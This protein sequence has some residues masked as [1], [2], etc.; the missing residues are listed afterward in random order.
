V[1]NEK[2]TIINGNF[3]NEIRRMELFKDKNLK[4]TFS[5]HD[6]F[7]CRQFWLKKGYD[8]VFEQ[9][10]FSNDNAVVKLGVGK[11][12]VSAIRYWL[13]AFTITDSQDLITPFGFELLGDNGLDPFLEDDGSLWLL[14]YNL[15]KSGHA[16]IY[17]IIFN[18]FRR[19]KIEF[20]RESFLAFIKR[21]AE[22]EKGINFNEKTIGEDFIVFRKMYLSADKSA[23]D[24]LAGLLSDLG[25][26]KKIEK[27]IDDKKVDFFVI[28]NTERPQIPVE[29]FLYSILDNENYTNSISLNSLVQDYNSPGSIFAMNSHGIIEK[30]KEAETKYR[31][32][33]YNDNA[34]VKEIQ[35]R[36]KP[37]PFTV[38]ED[39]Y[40]QE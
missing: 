2:L 21:K 26:I 5:G 14:H 8:F 38:L 11:N 6:S 34:G 19:E 17:S 31:W 15:V 24:E 27:E 3:T 12:M 22:T 39:Y 13:R 29:I 7:Q 32:L 9:S 23:D 28:E 36:N 10:G 30:I 33:T 25:L 4:F 18:E 16:S 20:N 35:L 1:L 40:E 37:E